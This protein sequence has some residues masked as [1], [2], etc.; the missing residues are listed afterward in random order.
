MHWQRHHRPQTGGGGLEFPFTIGGDVESTADGILVV[1]RA[2]KVTAFNRIF[3]ELWRIPESLIATRDDEQLLQYAVDLLLEPDAF[4]DKVRAL[5]RTPEVSSVDELVFKDGRIFKRYSQPQRID[6]TIVGRVWSFRDITDRKQA[7]E[8]M[9]RYQRQWADIIEFLPD[10]TFV[11]DNEGTVIAWNRAMEAMSGIS[12]S[13]MIGK[14]DFEYSLP[15]FGY[16]RPILIDLLFASEE[17]KTEY[18]DPVSTV[19]GNIVAET[20]APEAYGGKGAYLWGVATAL[21]DEQGNVTGAIESIRDITERK[22]AQDELFNSRQMLRSVLDN[23]PQRVFWKDRN[24]AFVGCNKPFV[25][26]CGYKDPSEL[27]GK[28]SY[29]TA[30]AAMADLYSDDDREVMESGR[31]KLNYEEAQIRPD[32]SQA[33]LITSKVPMYDQEGQVIGVLGTY[34][35]ITERKMAEDALRESEERFSKFFRASPVGTSIS[36]LSDG[37]FVDVNDAFLGFLAIHA[38]RSS[39]TSALELGMWVDPGNRAKMVG[40]LQEH[41]R[42]RDFERQGVRKSGEIIDVL[43]F[44]R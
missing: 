27:V 8:A 12:K 38:R 34:S 33:W 19:G 22:R 31:P 2:G 7:E 37:Q 39:V 6:D 24:S 18:Y 40:I 13:K 5:Y 4:L 30:S 1:D 44:G 3:L 16:R 42:I 41:G 21:F 29:E 10:A 23:I 43:S 36:R 17:K 32:G 26:D 35:D 28:T 25:L 11:I 20:Y 14:G 9:R 15:F